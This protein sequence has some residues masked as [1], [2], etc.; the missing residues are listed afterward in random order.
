ML[1]FKHLTVNKSAEA[2]PGDRTHTLVFREDGVAGALSPMA[3]NGNTVT[4]SLTE[5]E[6]LPYVLGGLY[7]IT[8]APAESPAVVEE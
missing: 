5:A 1:R 4:L 2:L 7:E 3:A 6:A 8:L